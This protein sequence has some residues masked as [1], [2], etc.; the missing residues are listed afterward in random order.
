MM[1]KGGRAKAHKISSERLDYMSKLRKWPTYQCGRCSLTQQK[2]FLEIQPI[3][4][5]LHNNRTLRLIALILHKQY[6]SA[7]IY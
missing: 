6:K 7:I 2:P 4:Q 3:Q 1:E 5:I